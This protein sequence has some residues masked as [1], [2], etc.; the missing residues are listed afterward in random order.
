MTQTTRGQ[1]EQWQDAAE[2]VAAKLQAFYDGLAEDE[3]SLFELGVRRL[4]AGEGTDAGGYMIN[5]HDVNPPTP[6]PDRQPGA[7]FGFPSVWL[8]SVYFPDS[9]STLP[10]NP[11]G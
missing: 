5:H 1:Q 4:V 9:G 8:D 7:G 2:R 10:L 6:P 3:R 11:P